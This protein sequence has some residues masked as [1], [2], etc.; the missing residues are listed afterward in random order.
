MKS[1]KVHTKT[2]IDI[3]SGRVERDEWYLHDGLWVHATP[4]MA[5]FDQDSYAFYNDDGSE[6][7]STQIGSTN[8]QQTLA[9][10]TTFFAR[11]LIQEF[12]GGSG[13][14]GTPEWEYSTDGG[15]G[16]TDVTTSS[17]VIQAV[18][19]SNVTDGD[20]TTQRIGG[21]TFITPNAWVTDDGI[22]PNLIFAG[23]DECECLLVFQI[24]GSDV[25]NG[26]EILLRM[27]NIDT[28][29]RNA[30]IDVSKAAAARRVMVIS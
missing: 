30:D 14:L 26:D 22:P 4:A 25:S 21:G 27:F 15:T 18:V 9:V 1:R 20:D 5:Q 3:D 28:Y 23:N 10:D 2:I 13:A 11:L 19:S 6:S 16:W 8:V 7:A 12:N 17:S 24:I 29:T